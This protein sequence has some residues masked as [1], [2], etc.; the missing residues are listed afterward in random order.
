MMPVSFQHDDWT[1]DLIRKIQAHY[2][3]GYFTQWEL[4]DFYQV[5]TSLVGKACRIMRENGGQKI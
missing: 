1:T 5:S 4:A 2:K 3:T